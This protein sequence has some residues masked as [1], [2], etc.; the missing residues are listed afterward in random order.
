MDCFMQAAPILI[1]CSR[2]KILIVWKF[3]K[4]F[5][6][7]FCF[8]FSKLV[9]HLVWVWKTVS[10]KVLSFLFKK[11]ETSHCEFWTWYKQLDSCKFVQYYETAYVNIYTY[12]KYTC[13]YN[14]CFLF[15]FFADVLSVIWILVLFFH[16]VFCFWLLSFFFCLL[17]ILSELFSFFYQ[18][19][20]ETFFF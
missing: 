9:S 1:L 12:L 5:F 14:L 18:Y 11:K 19:I 8:F 10:C 17:C 16:R 6:L 3:T 7:V 2:G 13:N 15:V 4:C 20:R